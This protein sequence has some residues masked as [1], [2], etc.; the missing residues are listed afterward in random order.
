MCCFSKNQI[1]KPWYRRNDTDERN[2]KARRA[3]QALMTVTLR[4]PD[5]TEYHKFSEEVKRRAREQYGD[6]IYGKE[7]VIEG[8]G[9]ERGRES[10]RDI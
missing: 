1:E 9:R 10:G 8:G 6:H 5:S 4:K 7:E 3:Y 2:D